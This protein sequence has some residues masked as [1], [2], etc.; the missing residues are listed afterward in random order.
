MPFLDLRTDTLLFDQGG[1]D[2]IPVLEGKIAVD[3]G[4]DV[5]RLVG[6]FDQDRA[7][8]AERIDDDMIC[9]HT[10]K[11][12][13]SRGKGL[14]EGRVARHGAVAALVQRGACRVKIDADAVFED[15]E[16]DLVHAAAFFKPRGMI[17]RFQLLH[18]RL[19]DDLLARGNGRQSGIDAVALDRKSVALADEAA[20]ISR[21]D[22]LEQRVKILRL[23]LSHEN[24]HSRAQ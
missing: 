18:D 16:L 7:A 11:L 24:E 12:H 5:H 19:F 15:T 23:K 21:P 9:A 4:H 20:P 13:H 22:A 3:S 2:T 14:F 6:G 17:L 1:V 10:G 8:A